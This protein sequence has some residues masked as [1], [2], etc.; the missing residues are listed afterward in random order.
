VSAVAFPDKDR[1]IVHRHVSQCEN[2]LVR[3]KSHA[4]VFTAA[5]IGESCLIR[6]ALASA[7]ELNVTR[8][9]F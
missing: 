4:R 9:A 2:D 3:T 7:R 6:S 5:F 8:S 1:R